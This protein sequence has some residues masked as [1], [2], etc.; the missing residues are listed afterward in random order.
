[1]A[2]VEEQINVLEQQMSSLS[3]ED[4]IRFKEF[5]C[6]VTGIGERSAHLLYIYTNGLKDFNSAGQLLNFVGIVPRS[7]KSGKSVNKKGKITKKGPGELRACLYCAARSAK[8]HNLACKAIFER[9]RKQGKPYKVA[10]IA[11]IKKLLQQV[12]VVVKSEVKFDNNR[13]LKNKCE[14]N[15]IF[16]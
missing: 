10:M 12:Y 15:N 4:E 8:K 14:K 2:T 3:D 16:L 13:Y 9:L 5:A 7:H 1:M 11:V 6:S